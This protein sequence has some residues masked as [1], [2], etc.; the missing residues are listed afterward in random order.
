MKL[1]EAFR[2]SHQIR[3]YQVRESFSRS[4]PVYIDDIYL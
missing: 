2:L 1:S 4:S 3:I